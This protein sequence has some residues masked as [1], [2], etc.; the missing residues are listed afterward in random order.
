MY[1]IDS[2]DELLQQVEVI[3]ENNRNADGSRPPAVAHVCIAAIRHVGDEVAI[4]HAGD[5]YIHERLSV[6]DVVE[7]APRL[8]ALQSDA[9]HIRD[10]AVEILAQLLTNYYDE[11]GWEDVVEP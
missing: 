4:L 3:A 10:Y 6:G 7:H 5:P 2:T 11:H 9:D 8:T 1:E